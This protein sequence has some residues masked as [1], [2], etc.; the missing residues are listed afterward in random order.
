[1]KKNDKKRHANLNDL[2]I[3]NILFPNQSTRFKYKKRKDAV[4]LLETL[5]EIYPNTNILEPEELKDDELVLYIY[6]LKY[7]K[8]PERQ[9]KFKGEFVK[10]KIYFNKNDKA[11]SFCF[12]FILTDK[13]PY[14]IRPRK[15]HPDWGVPE[16]RS[17]KRKTFST[18]SE[19][20]AIYDKIQAEYQKVSIRK[21]MDTLFLHVYQKSDTHNN[22]RKYIFS[23]EK[24]EDGSYKVAIKLNSF[25][26]NTL[27]RK[28]FLIYPVTCVQKMYAK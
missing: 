20:R 19:I 12:D 22:V 16:L 11:Y 28:K 7:F 1:M 25:Q 13:H 9:K 5:K 18:R 23:A 17:L 21:D 6:G 26:A 8:D 27:K 14:R 24:L 15:T 4:E 3:R 2:R 10:I